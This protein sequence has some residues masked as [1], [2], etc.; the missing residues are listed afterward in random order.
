MYSATQ[1]KLLQFFHKLFMQNNKI[2]NKKKMM[3]ITY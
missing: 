3:V 2:E 1:T